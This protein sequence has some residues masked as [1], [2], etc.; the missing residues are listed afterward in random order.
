VAQVLRDEELGLRG[1]PPSAR[2]VALLNQT[3]SHGYSRGR[4]RLI[5][6]FMLRSSRI[7]GVAIGAVRSAE[8]IFEVQ[9]HIGAVV[10]AGGM[11]RRMGQLK[12]LMPWGGRRTIIEHIIEQL[13]LARVPQV[14]V[15]TG[16]RAG[17]VRQVV[18]RV[19]ADVVH[20][21]KYT[22]GEMLSSLQ[23]GLRAMPAHI[24]AA[25][26]VLGDQPHIQ[27]KIVAQ[28]MMA[29]AEGNGDIVAPSYHMR[30]GHPIL[31]DRRYWAEILDLP[32]D[33]SLRDVMDRHKDR[34]GYVNVD[35]DSVLRDV[36]TQ[37]DYR[38]ER[39]LAGLD[40]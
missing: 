2:I 31:I 21:D 33:G 27:P 15:V 1:V 11:S 24:S 30:R 7:H 14:T 40:G 17:E 34:I 23:A 4:A 39:K 37:E 13:A 28:V 20:N 18:S 29:Y 6:Q 3:A 22:T 5:A 25:L 32:E 26:L 19:G 35:T 8:P 9:K 12:V 38:Q 16:H 36:D 10:L